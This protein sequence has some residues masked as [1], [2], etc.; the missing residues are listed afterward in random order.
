MVVA[1]RCLQ[2]VYAAL[3]RVE[4]GPQYA[5]RRLVTYAI[6]EE[7]AAVPARADVTQGKPALAIVLSSRGT[8]C[9]S[10]AYLVRALL[11]VRLLFYNSRACCSFR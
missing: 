3:L 10:S 1:K 8:R 9:Q 6:N 2:R 5:V 11:R 4:C 7:V